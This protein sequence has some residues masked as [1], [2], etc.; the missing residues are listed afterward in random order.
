MSEPSL[1][2]TSNQLSIKADFIYKESFNKSV[3]AKRL[4]ELCQL[5]HSSPRGLGQLLPPNPPR[6]AL[7]LSLS[8]YRFLVTIFLFV[9]L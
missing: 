2:F 3:D 8:L 5:W 7:S 6:L 4:S 9:V 1:L